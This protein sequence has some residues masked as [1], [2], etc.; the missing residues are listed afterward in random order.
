MT[1]VAKCNAPG[2]RQGAQANLKGLKDGYVA[3]YS[4]LHSKARLGVNDDKRKAALLRDPRVEQLKR[5]ASIELMPA[6]QL[7]DLQNRLAALQSC[8]ALTE[9]EL[10]AAPICPH[11]HFTPAT[12]PTPAPAGTLLARIDDELDTLLSAWTRTLLENVEDPTTG[13][14][15]DLLSVD[16]RGQIDNFV[17]ARA[18]PEPLD[19]GFIQAAQEVLSGLSKVVVTVDSLRAALLDGGSPATT[20]ELKGRFDEYLGGLTKGKDPGKVR[21]VLE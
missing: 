13:A 7:T 16:H 12:E 3:A 5:L 6:S 15:L 4:A 8:F 21:I 2:F 19:G 9:Q 14:S 10:Q 11:C 20:A 1:A 17:A 18:L